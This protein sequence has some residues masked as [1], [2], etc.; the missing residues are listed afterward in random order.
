MRGGSLP[1]PGRRRHRSQSTACR[2]PRDR[3]GP[4]FARRCSG[5][6]PIPSIAITPRLPNRH[7]TIAL[8]RSSA[9]A[10]T[11]FTGTGSDSSRRRKCRQAHR[12][13]RCDAGGKRG[14]THDVIVRD[15][16]AVTRCALDQVARSGTA[17][18]LEFARLRA[19]ALTTSSIFG[20]PPEPGPTGSSAT[21]STTS[22]I[23]TPAHRARRVVPNSDHIL[24][25]IRPF[26]CCIRIVA[27]QRLDRVVGNGLGLRSRRTQ[28][29]LHRR[30]NVVDGCSAE[31]IVRMS[32]KQ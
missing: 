4:R 19:R 3:L 11:R 24:P 30:G 18:R 17:C 12:G 9:D 31:R 1:E 27:K 16:V 15:S 23:A 13:E 29:E 26:S 2:D 10:N 22:M 21:F 14:D 25:F 28:T 8:E 7:L 6:R 5:D 20:P 32:L